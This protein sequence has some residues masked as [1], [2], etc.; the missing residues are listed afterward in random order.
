MVLCGGVVLE[1]VYCVIIQREC[2]NVKYKNPV[3]RKKRGTFP[4]EV[5]CGYC[6][7]PMLIYAKGSNGNLIKLQYPRII[8]SAMNLQNHEGHIKCVNCRRK[9]ATRGVFG[10][11]VTYWIVRGKVSTRKLQHY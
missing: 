3:Y 11:S 7:T 6:H 4:L 9:L 1:S 2:N 10:E 5:S 8:A